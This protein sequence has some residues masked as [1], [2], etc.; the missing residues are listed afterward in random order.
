MT[1]EK[2]LS[3]P[4][5][6]DKIRVKSLIS[7]GDHYVEYR[8]RSFSEDFVGTWRKVGASQVENPST[9][10]FICKDCVSHSESWPKIQGITKPVS[11]QCPGRTKNYN[12]YDWSVGSCYNKSTCWGAA[13]YLFEVKMMKNIQYQFTHKKIIDLNLPGYEVVARYNATLSRKFSE[14][15][16]RH[17]NHGIALTS[18]RLQ[19][20]FPKILDEFSG[21]NIFIY[22]YTHSN[23]KLPPHKRY[24]YDINMDSW[25]DEFQDG[26]YRY[27]NHL[28]MEYF[29][30]TPGL[31]HPQ[32][33][34]DLENHHKCVGS[35]YLELYPGGG[36]MKCTQYKYVTNSSFDG[37]PSAVLSKY[38]DA[39]KNRHL[40]DDQPD[41]TE[42]TWINNSHVYKCDAFVPNFRDGLAGPIISYWARIDNNR[43][44]FSAPIIQPKYT[45]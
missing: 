41:E 24:L 11:Y 34:W 15:D 13:E 2:R 14:T 40:V 21:G 32:T 3:I 42:A 25:P 27:P 20:F 19:M 37:F 12:R 30:E 39:R 1:F 18:R 43:R 22:I 31:K 33:I 44:W 35:S 16:D 4:N 17:V 26:V 38:H 28:A 10:T 23:Y 29:L 5:F 36:G 7:L 9:T 8:Y 6:Y 45:N